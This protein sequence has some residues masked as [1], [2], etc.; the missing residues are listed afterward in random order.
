MQKFAK[1][2]EVLRLGRSVCWGLVGLGLGSWIVFLKPG[3]GVWILSKNNRKTLQVFRQ[4]S[5]RQN[6]PSLCVTWLFMRWG[7]VIS[8]ELSVCIGEAFSPGWFSFWLPCQGPVP[9]LCFSSLVINKSSMGRLLK[10]MQILIS[11]QKF[12][13]LWHPLMIFA[14][15][16]LSCDGCKMMIF[17]PPAL[18]PHL[19]GGHWH[20]AVRNHFVSYL[21]IDILLYEFMNFYFFQWFIVF[22]VCSSFG[23]HIFPDLA[24]ESIWVLLM[25][26]QHFLSVSLFFY[27]HKIPLAHS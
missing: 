10:T 24:R 8:A 23:A 21:F 2:K 12:P 17:L 9:F 19:L 25:S 5:D 13:L 22:T 7:S 14:W 18:S 11:H 15:F 20:F 1:E 27:S 16:S 6:F 3:H 26:S 4:G